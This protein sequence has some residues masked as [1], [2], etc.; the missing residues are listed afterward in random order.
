MNKDLMLVFP[1]SLGPVKAY[2]G[3]I[4]IISRVIVGPFRK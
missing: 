3:N 4:L 2:W 1:F